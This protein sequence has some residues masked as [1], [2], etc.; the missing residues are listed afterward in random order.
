MGR[1]A[2]ETHYLAGEGGGVPGQQQRRADPSARKRGDQPCLPG[3]RSVFF[4]EELL[5]FRPGEGGEAAGLG[6]IA[7]CPK[8]WSEAWVLVR[9]TEGANA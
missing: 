2:K 6:I 8:A 5:H 9:G 1:K 4:P 7:S 3:G